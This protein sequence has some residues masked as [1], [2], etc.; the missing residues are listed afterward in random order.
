[1]GAFMSDIFPVLEAKVGES[2]DDVE[3]RE[4]CLQVIITLWCLLF[5]RFNITRRWIV[6]EF[7]TN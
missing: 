2:D 7:I 6:K 3:L 5:S 4:A 1:M